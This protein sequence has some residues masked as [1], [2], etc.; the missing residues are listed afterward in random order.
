MDDSLG[1]D[2]SGLASIIRTTNKA[3]DSQTAARDPLPTLF[4]S[5]AMIQRAEEEEEED[6]VVKAWK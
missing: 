4:I 2:T 3:K 5:V 1:V 6:Q